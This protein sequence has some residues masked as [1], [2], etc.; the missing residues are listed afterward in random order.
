MVRR[1]RPRA[2]RLAGAAA[3]IAA[4]LMVF[5]AAH[6]AGHDESAPE[7]LAGCVV[8]TIAHAADHIAPTSATTIPSPSA[9]LV[10]SLPAVTGVPGR[11]S[12]AL[13]LR[14]RGPPA[15]SPAI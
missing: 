12:P 14:S 15:S 6:A 9:T 4:L 7:A 8:C 13:A 2:G 10:E 11:A 5:G 3:I 1:S